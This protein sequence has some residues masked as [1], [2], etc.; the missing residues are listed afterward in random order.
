MI[1][2][3]SIYSVSGPSLVGQWTCFPWTFWKQERLMLLS[4]T[5]WN[6]WMTT[7][8][9]RWHASDLYTVNF[10]LLH[11]YLYRVQTHCS[12]KVM[13]FFNF[14]CKMDFE[15]TYFEFCGSPG[16]NVSFALNS[17]KKIPIYRCLMSQL[18][19]LVVECW[20]RVWEVPGSIPFQRLHYC[21]D[22]NKN[23]TSSS[24]V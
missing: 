9:F 8:S 3:L 13:K 7:F 12:M 22:D 4:D 6:L 24:F 17:V 23:G 16:C 11:S 2:K 19:S 10:H 20:L 5:T 1:Y 14:E 18:N 21:E 15:K